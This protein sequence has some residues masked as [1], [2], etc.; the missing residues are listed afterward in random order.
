MVCCGGLLVVCFA[1]FSVTCH[2][3]TNLLLLCSVF[4]YLLCRKGGAF[5]RSLD[6]VHRQLNVNSDNSFRPR[7]DHGSSC[8]TNHSVSV[9]GSEGAGGCCSA[10]GEKAPFVVNG[11]NQLLWE[12]SE[13]HMLDFIM[14][15]YLAILVHTLMH[16]IYSAIFLIS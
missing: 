16:N 1:T 14:Q 4:L 13:K 8:G 5:D 3:Q 10:S 9:T 6:A 7:H 2:V 15:P 11:N 12:V